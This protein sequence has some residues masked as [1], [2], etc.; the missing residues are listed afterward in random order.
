M[1]YGQLENSEYITSCGPLHSQDLSF[2]F[3]GREGERDPGN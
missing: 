2:H 1:H 3:S